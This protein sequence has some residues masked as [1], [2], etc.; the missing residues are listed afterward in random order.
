MTTI[1]RC[2]FYRAID[3]I[4]GGVT[5]FCEAG[6]VNP[7]VVNPVLVFLRHLFRGVFGRNGDGISVHV[8]NGD[9]TRVKAK[10]RLGSI[11][12]FGEL[13]LITRCP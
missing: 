7:M 8:L 12:R 4:A 10:D 5:V 3:D 13:S 11:S 1:T 9:V 2:A 6:S